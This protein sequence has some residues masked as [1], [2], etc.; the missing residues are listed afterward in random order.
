MLII[1]ICCVV[2]ISDSRKDYRNRQTGLITLGLLV[3]V[4]VGYLHGAQK[5]PVVKRYY[6]GMD[7]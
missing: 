5:E 3:A 2:L 4:G 1:R 6:N 7:M